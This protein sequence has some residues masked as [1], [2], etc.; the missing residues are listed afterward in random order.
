MFPLKQ[1]LRKEKDIKMV[2]SGKLSFYNAFFGLKAR[3]N[4]S[5]ADRFA[6][7]V[8]KKVDKTAVG[9]NLIKRRIKAAARQFS[10]KRATNYDFVIIS[11]PAAKDLDFP[12]VREHIHNLLSRVR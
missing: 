12:G 2:F 3:R 5:D 7:M 11:L 9:R 1:R 8:S 10:G 4:S 6:V